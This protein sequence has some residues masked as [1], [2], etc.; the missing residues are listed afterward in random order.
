MNNINEF[1]A[2]I[3]CKKWPSRWET[4]F[5]EVCGDFEKNGCELVNPDY[6]DHLHQKYGILNE[7]LDVYKLAAK[8]IAKSSELSLFLHLMCRALKDRDRIMGDVYA[9][10]L[11]ELPEGLDPIAINMLCGLA[12]CSQMD[13]C[14]NNLVSRDI[15]QHMI[16]EIMNMPEGGARRYFQRNNG[17][18]GYSLF[19]WYQL[20]IDGKLYN[21]NRLEIE[22]NCPFEFSVRVYG[23]G[24]GDYITLADGID[25]HRSGHVLGTKY[26][27]DEEGSWRASITEQD[28]YICGYT[29]GEDVLLKRELIKLPKDEWTEL[30]K[31]DDPIVNLHIPAKGKL[32]PELVD[33]AMEEIKKFL[34]KHYPDYKYKAFACCSWLLDPQNE[35]LLGKDTNISKFARRFQRFTVKDAGRSVFSFVY[36]ADNL[37]IEDLPEDTRLQVELKK[38]FLAGKAIYNVG[39]YFFG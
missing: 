27:E 22:V 35:I 26:F 14:Y 15:P 17:K 28:G 25:V 7:F 24:K 29:Y 3:G 5:D 20:A 6:Y 8:E 39:G 9:Y 1:M 12:I 23:N 38:H 18:Y 34:K 33:E 4:F 30:L 11:P 2:R 19:D 21:I 32:T 16:D 13:Y 37:A 10:S 31:K 36:R